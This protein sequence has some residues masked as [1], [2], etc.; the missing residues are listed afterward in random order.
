MADFHRR[1]ERIRRRQGIHRIERVIPDRVNP[2][3]FLSRSEVRGRYRFHPESILFLV[4]LLQNSLEY[5]TFRSSPLPSVISLLVTL[6]YFASGT[7]YV[8]IGDM[9]GVS[10]S[11]VSRAIVRTSAAICGLRNRFI[12]FPLNNEAVMT[13]RE[14]YNI[15]LINVHDWLI[16]SP[17]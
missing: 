6:H 2:L 17:M 3:E 4:Q 9:H 14:F 8:I 16:T 1:L 7:H 13:Q 12:K 5:A 11:S 15:G 10:K